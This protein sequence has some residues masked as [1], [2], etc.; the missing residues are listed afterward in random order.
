VFLIAQHVN[1][2]FRGEFNDMRKAILLLDVNFLF[3]S[4]FSQ[5]TEP[6]GWDTPIT[7]WTV[8]LAKQTIQKKSVLLRVDNKQTEFESLMQEENN[9]CI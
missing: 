3:I 9:G 5:T 7:I 2:L 6:T 1:Y 8:L 4:T